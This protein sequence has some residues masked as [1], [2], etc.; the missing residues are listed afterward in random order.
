MWVSELA[1]K[2][3]EVYLS[4]ASS[5]VLR[6]PLSWHKNAKLWASCIFVAPPVPTPFV[7]S[8]AL[9][10]SR[11]ISLLCASSFPLIFPCD[12]PLL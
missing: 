4:S 11:Y 6:K 1:Q 8:L 7:L 5:K 3:L 12:G 10:H 9:N 2:G